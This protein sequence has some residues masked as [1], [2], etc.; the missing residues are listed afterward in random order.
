LTVVCPVASG[1][2]LEL[3]LDHSCREKEVARQN[4]VADKPAEGGR[5]APNPPGLVQARDIWTLK[6]TRR[7]VGPPTDFLQA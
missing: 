3:G 2:I 4:F 5:C 1:P 7:S 6:L